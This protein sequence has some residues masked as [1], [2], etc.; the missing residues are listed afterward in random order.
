MNLET[1]HFTNDHEWVHVENDIATVGISNHAASEL[2]EVVFVELPNITTI[3]NQ[4]DELGTVESVK[5][6]SSVYTP[7][8]G[9]VI[10]V[11]EELENQPEMI[12]DSPYQNGW[13]VKLKVDDL[14]EI[15]DLMTYT[16][17]QTYLETL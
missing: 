4:K 10:E 3:V 12:N 8:S 16:E 6:V 7:L 2:G 14:Q 15:D 13:L 5:T 1:C 11:N 17:Y 9:R